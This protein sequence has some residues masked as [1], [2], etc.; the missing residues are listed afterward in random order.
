MFGQK[1]FAK[2]R[3]IADFNYCSPFFWT[4]VIKMLKSYS[5]YFW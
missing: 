2:Y 1:I 4:P 3:R 5:D